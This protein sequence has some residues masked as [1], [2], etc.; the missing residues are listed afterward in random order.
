MYTLCMNHPPV[1][2]NPDLVDSMRTSRSILRMTE[3][4]LNPRVR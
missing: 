4:K 3:E 2:S 1:V